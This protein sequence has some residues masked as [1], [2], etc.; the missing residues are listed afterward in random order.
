MGRWSHAQSIVITAAIGVATM[1]VQAQTGA[2]ASPPPATPTPQEEITVTAQRLNAARDNIEPDLGATTYN[3]TQQ[4]IESLPQGEN[5]PLNE[6]LLQAP[7]VNQDNLANGAIHVRNEHL[8][9]QYRINGVIIP[10][11]VSF[12]GQG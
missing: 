7:G 4:T 5:A 6:V 9:V 8:G 11:G 10:D 1:P 12:F 2:T 3:F